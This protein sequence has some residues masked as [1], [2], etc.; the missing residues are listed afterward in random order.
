MMIQQVTGLKK[1][2]L[3][4]VN[5]DLEMHKYYLLI[6]FLIESICNGET[7]KIIEIQKNLPII[8]VKIYHILIEENKYE[9]DIFSNA[10]VNKNN[11]LSMRCKIDNRMKQILTEIMSREYDFL[12]MNEIIDGSVNDYSEYFILF[13]NVRIYLGKGQYNIKNKDPSVNELIKILN[14]NTECSD[15]DE[16]EYFTMHNILG[17]LNSLAEIKEFFDKRDLIN[18][19]TGEI[20]SEYIPE[21]EN[22][23]EYEYLL[24]SINEGLT[25]FPG[26]IA[27]FMNI[28]K[29][30]FLIKKI[31]SSE[32]LMCQL[33][34]DKLAF[35][36]NEIHYFESSFQSSNMSKEIKKYKPT[37]C[38]YKKIVLIDG[39]N[40]QILGFFGSL[41]RDKHTGSL[42]LKEM[43]KIIRTG[44]DCKR[45]N[46]PV[47][48]DNHIKWL[49]E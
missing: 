40:Q 19:L 16:N 31:D 7:I 35:L 22:M 46:L 23:F 13:N 37:T 26:N 27:I 21:T 8:N 41:G 28:S 12:L 36:E 39:R 33:S 4:V 9:I 3:I 24:I 1:I 29:N 47:L 38:P 5:E 49:I 48:F 25:I 34:K 18:I 30:E 6:I 45:T 14:E 20:L 42:N 44:C 11:Y 17:E 2:F 15:I 43:E 32:G 10:E